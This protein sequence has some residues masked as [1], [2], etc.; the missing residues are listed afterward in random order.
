MQSISR[1]LQL[2]RND[3]INVRI[4]D[5][6]GSKIQ[7]D[8]NDRFTHFVGYLLEHD[9]EFDCEK[10]ATTKTSGIITYNTTTLNHGY[11]IVASTGIFTAPKPGMYAFHFHGQSR[12]AQQSTNIILR[13]NN[14]QVA[15]IHEGSE[16]NKYDQMLS[17]SVV[18]KLDKTDQVDVYL[19]NGQLRD[20]TTWKY[21][22]FI[23]YL[24]F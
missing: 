18:L 11:G 10:Y 1:V 23:G 7:D 20:A 6:N 5:Y 8:P 13:H 17:M 12:E 3:E 2:N 24:L 21:T 19:K 4:D 9:V 14:V 22:N 16:S 15:G